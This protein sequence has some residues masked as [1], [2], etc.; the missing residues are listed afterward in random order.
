MKHYFVISVLFHVYKCKFYPSGIQIASKYEVRFPFYFPLDVY[1]LSQH[2]FSS[3]NLKCHHYHISN[4]HIY[5]DLFSIFFSTPDL[6][7]GSVLYY[8]NY[9][10]FITYFDI[11]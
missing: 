10:G 5:M 2:Y 9:Y 8:F 1:R 7:H 11:F 3:T 6:I 4:S